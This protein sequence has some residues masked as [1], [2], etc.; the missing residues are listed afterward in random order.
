MLTFRRPAGSAT[1]R[2]F[3]RR[4]VDSLGAR[5]DG[6][7]NRV[8]QVGEDPPVAWLSHTDTVHQDGGRH[9][10][11]MHGADLFTLDETSHCLGADDTAGVWMMREMILA[12]VPGLY[13]FHRA[14]EVGC[15]GSA[16]IAKHTPD[17]LDGIRYAVSLD[18]AGYDSV[19]THQMG[20]RTASDEFAYALADLLNITTYAPDPTGT[21][22]DSNEY[23]R[24]VPECTNLS[25]GYHNAH[26]NDE[27][28]NAYF[29]HLLLDRLIE[30]GEQV[31]TLPVA[32][33]PAV[34]E[35]RG[36]Y[37]LNTYGGG[38]TVN[39]A[40]PVLSG[41]QNSEYYPDDA[42]EDPYTDYTED[43]ADAPDDVCFLCLKEFE[44]GDWTKP[45][46]GAQL[47]LPCYETAVK[48]YIENGTVDAGG[49]E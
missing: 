8:L 21:Y 38:P 24:L 16:W 43:P 18:R 22:T 23:R 34:V 26:S 14:E 36:A 29:A 10:V 48:P 32:R 47:C 44:P 27:Y 45:W 7:G 41:H 31:A 15:R 5:P 19:I 35:R 37:G 11:G 28:Q 12:R 25:V 33:N 1:E 6:Y 20:T 9:P 40:Q 13:I 39:Y 17:L 3:I 4:Y 42:A 46:E 30:Y 49:V 2:D